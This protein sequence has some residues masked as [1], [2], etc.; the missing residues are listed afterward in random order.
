MKFGLEAE[1]SVEA[2]W[3]VG[4]CPISLLA[5]FLPTNS[6]LRHFVGRDT[7]S[8]CR[9]I[10]CVNNEMSTSNDNYTIHKVSLK[11]TRQACGPCR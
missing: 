7:K 8:I 6:N 1:Y 5:F 2:A 11:R 4:V 3:F 10:G 9:L